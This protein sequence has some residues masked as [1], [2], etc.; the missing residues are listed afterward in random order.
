[1]SLK[2]ARV[3][4][5]NARQEVRAGVDIVQAKR[6][7]REMMAAEAA[8]TAAPTFEQCAERY[9]E[10]QP[11][12]IPV[13]RCHWRYSTFASGQSEASSDQR[14]KATERRVFDGPAAVLQGSA[15]R[16]ASWLP[17]LS[18]NHVL[19]AALPAEKP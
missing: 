19:A 14:S 9:I 16:S 4:R 2:G 7:A 15:R 8:T 11:S 3:K 18:V 5:D 10:E 13:S 12:S 1:V 6:S 17:A